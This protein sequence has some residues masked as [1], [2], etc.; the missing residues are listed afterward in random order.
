MSK[1]SV[2]RVEDAVSCYPTEMLKQVFPIG[3]PKL[4]I[5]ESLGSL[6]YRDGD[7]YFQNERCWGAV[8]VRYEVPK[9]TLRPYMVYQHEKIV[10]SLA[11]CYR[12]SQ[13]QSIKKCPHAS[14]NRQFTQT[15]TLADCGYL[16][17]LGYD[18]S[19][20]HI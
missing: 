15:M 6:E 10:A 9:D 1:K 11:N 3:K 17:E 2:L 4:I 5:G 19:L 20:I 18:L 16:I 8:Q 14:F 12:C 7:F 13:L